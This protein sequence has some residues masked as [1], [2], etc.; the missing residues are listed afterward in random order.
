VTFSDNLTAPGDEALKRLV[1]DA[2]GKLLDAGKSTPGTPAA[3]TPTPVAPLPPGVLRPAGGRVDGAA[4]TEVA[5]ETSGNGHRTVGWAAVGLGGALIA[6]G[7]YSV[8]RLNAIDTDQ[9]VELYRQGFHSS[10]DVC[11]EARAGTEAKVSGAAS[12]T[13]MRDFC[14]TAT[15]FQTLQYIFFGLGAISAGAGIYMLASDKGA[16]TSST[17]HVRLAP[18]IGRSG[19][20]LD[21]T[22]AF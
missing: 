4:S 13:E 17:T 5:E 16:P 10:A 20:R 22:F 19:G 7:V 14:S 12:A 2:L 18:S 1:D 11:D 8:V 3:S 15:T 6:G 9:K 21:V